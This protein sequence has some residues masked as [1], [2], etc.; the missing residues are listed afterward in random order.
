MCAPSRGGAPT[1]TAQ[2]A[3][4][5]YTGTANGLTASATWPA[6]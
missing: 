6:Q 2:P 5:K 1:S 4:A 3:I